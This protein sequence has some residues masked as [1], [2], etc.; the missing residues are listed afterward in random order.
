VSR[1]EKVRHTFFRC[2]QKKPIEIYPIEIYPIEI[3]PIEIN[4]IEI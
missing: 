4:P 2:Y 1:E 3:N